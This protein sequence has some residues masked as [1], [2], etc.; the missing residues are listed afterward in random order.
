ME[1]TYNEIVAENKRLQDSLDVMIDKNAELIF[2][3]KALKAE[4]QKLKA[5]LEGKSVVHDYQNCKIM[6][7]NRLSK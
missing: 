5:Q 1:R 6:S 4:I 7:I 2:R 3:E